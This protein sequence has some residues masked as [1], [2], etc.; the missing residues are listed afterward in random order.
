MVLKRHGLTIGIERVDHEVY[1]SIKAVGTLTHEDYKT[2]TPMVDGALAKVEHPKANILF[3][4]TELE[5]WELR[6]AWDDLKLGLKH[7]SEFE[8]IAICGNK[9]WLQVAAK[10]GEWFVSGDVKYF[11]DVVDA[12]EWLANTHSSD[13]TS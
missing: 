4:A 12:L 5:G 9:R 11:D 6:A 1:I 8:K 7:G 2:I 10:I 3:D 13:I